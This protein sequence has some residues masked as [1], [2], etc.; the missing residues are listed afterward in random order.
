[1]LEPHRAVTSWRTP[2]NPLRGLAHDAEYIASYV[3]QIDGPVL[4]VGHSYGGAVI[5]ASRAVMLAGYLIRMGIMKVTRPE[6]SW[7]IEASG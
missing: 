4:L 3:N 7:W 6:R 5:L 1:V 2:P